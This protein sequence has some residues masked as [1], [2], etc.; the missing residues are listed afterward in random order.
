MNMLAERMMDLDNTLQ[1]HNEGEWNGGT[2]TYSA[3]NSGGVETEVG[4]FLYAFLRMMKPQNVLETGTH[5]GVGASY[6]G[7]ALKDNFKGLLET[8]EY[9]PELHNQAKERITKMGLDEYVKCYLMD[10]KNMPVQHNYQFI[11]L[12][13]EPQTRFEEFVKFYPYLDE[14]G[15]IFIHDLGRKLN[16]VDNKDLGFAWPFGPIPGNME[17]LLI[18][19]YVRPFHFDTPRGLSGFY[20]VHKEDYVIKR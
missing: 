13:T 15:Y 6:M 20:K 12:D 3:F 2:S 11:F 8:V 10:V 16:Q 7:F 5:L 1:I 9:I 17:H 4:E 19:D 18:H 14:G